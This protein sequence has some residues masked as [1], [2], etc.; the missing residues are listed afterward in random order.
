MAFRTIVLPF[1]GHSRQSQLMHL[2]VKCAKEFQEILW[3]HLIEKKKVLFAEQ[4]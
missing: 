1:E 2:Q 4:C 3:L